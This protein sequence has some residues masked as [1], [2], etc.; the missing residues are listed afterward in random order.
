MKENSKKQIYNL[1]LSSIFI[2]LATVL[3]MI[4]IYK[5]P[6][7]GAV[8]LL[9]MLPIIIVGCMLGKKWGIAAAFVYSLV[10]LGLGIALD[11]LFGWGLTPIC[12]VG[13]IL[14]DYILPF[15]MLGLVSLVSKRG[16]GYII[17]GTAAV[18]I[19]RF[20]CHFLSGYIIFANF[21]EFIVFGQ[22]FLS[23]PAFYSL[24]YN[25][26]YMLPELIITLIGTFLTVNLPQVKK[27]IRNG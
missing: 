23:K 19:L 4:K 16:T 18:V 5:L 14:L 20:L 8:T 6:L 26:S 11:G 27:L 15:T 13:T 22:S 1:T 25:G 12:L 3:S 10:Q 7:G 2:A 17:A 9:S 21:E 24:C